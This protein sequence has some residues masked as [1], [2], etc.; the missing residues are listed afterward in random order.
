ML[1]ICFSKEVNTN[2]IPRLCIRGNDIE[3]VTTFKLGG[4]FVCS[5][6][7]RDCHAVY[8]HQKVAE[9]MYSFSYIK[10]VPFCDV[11]SVYCAIIR[12]FLN[13]HVQFGILV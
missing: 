5:N 9:R 2:D 12:S 7:S 1:V 10:L 3:R 11:V 4:I 8:L 13:T 6:L